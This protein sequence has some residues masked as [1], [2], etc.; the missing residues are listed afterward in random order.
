MRDFVQKSIKGG[1]CCSLNQWYKSELSVYV[2]FILSTE[3]N[4]NGDIC[5]LMEKY[6]E[7]LNEERRLENQYD[8]NSDDYRIINDEEI[9]NYNSEKLSQIP[10]HMNLKQL[11]L[12]DTILDFDATSLYPSAMWDENSIYPKLESGYAFSPHIVDFFI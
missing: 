3:L 8:S 5:D 11:D 4:V 7:S 10:I 6:F 9:N 12:N 2:F 1:K